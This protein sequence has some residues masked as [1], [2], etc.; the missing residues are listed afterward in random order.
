LAALAHD[1]PFIFFST[2]LV[3][4]GKQGHYDEAAVPSPLNVYGETKVEA[5]QIVLS[6]PN[7]TVIRTSLNGGTSPT[8]DRGFN[9]EMRRAWQAGRTLKLFTDEFRS[10]TSAAVT[11]RAVWE[12]AAANQPGLYHVS[13]SERLSRWRIGELM[14]A[15]WPGLNPKIQPGSLREYEG[16]P[17]APDTSLNCSKAQRLLSFRLPGFTDWLEAHPEERF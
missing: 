17:R 12:L 1:I 15:R 5:E 11:A 2:D 4:D 3:F 14:A 10:P 13:G 16:P 7:H 9:E 8:G 6:N